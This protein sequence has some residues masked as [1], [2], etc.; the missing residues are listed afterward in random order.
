VLAQEKVKL[1]LPSGSVIVPEHVPEE[2][3]ALGNEELRVPLQLPEIVPPP[4]Q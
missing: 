2:D 4:L 3:V 1:L